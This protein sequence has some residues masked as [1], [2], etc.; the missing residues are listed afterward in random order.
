MSSKRNY[1]SEASRI[2]LQQLKYF[3]AVSEHL[4]FSKA[5]KALY[6][7][8]P[9]LS[10]QIS[11]LEQILNTQLFVRSNN[12]VFLTPD[13]KFFLA[14][15]KRILEKL[16]MATHCAACA[17]ANTSYPQRLRILCDELCDRGAL[18]NST[19][20]FMQD[21]P[22]ISCEIKIIPYYSAM[23]MLEQE[24]GDLIIV[25][26]DQKG[27]HEQIK[28]Q[29]LYSDC[30]DLIMPENMVKNGRRA[31]PLHAVSKLPLIMPERDTRLMNIAMQICTHLGI[32]PPISFAQAIPDIIL[33]IE[34]GSAFTMMPHLY[35]RRYKNRALTCF[36]QQD[37]PCAQ[38]PYSAYFREKSTNSVLPVLIRYFADEFLSDHKI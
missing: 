15:T 23:R 34:Q 14:E 7:S 26:L 19:F 8:Q 24:E 31:D 11:A 16:D 13:G 9:L 21:Y 27:I 17:A 20:K 12:A 1:V 29:I 2:E 25:S 35:I 18:T 4:H 37:L 32:S 10:Q 22:E 28:E 33:E 3:I 5:A 36:S 30:I 6:V 38:M